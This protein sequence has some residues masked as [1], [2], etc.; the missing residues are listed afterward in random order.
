MFVFYRVA[1]QQL[2][3]ASSCDVV[4][5][6]FLFLFKLSYRV[7]QRFIAEGGSVEGVVFVSFTLCVIA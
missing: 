2:C 4:S 5:I 3:S 7:L 1:F 6:P